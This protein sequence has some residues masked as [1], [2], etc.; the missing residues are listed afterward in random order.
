MSAA[1]RSAAGTFFQRTSSWEVERSRWFSMQADMDR[2]ALGKLPTARITVKS[3]RL[4]TAALAQ[5][6]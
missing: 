6:A 4:S 2:I 3:K 5:A 1:A